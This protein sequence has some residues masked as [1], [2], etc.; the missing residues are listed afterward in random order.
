MIPLGDLSDALPPFLLSIETLSRNIKIGKRLILFNDF[1]RYLFK[2]QI[3]QCMVRSC[4]SSDARSLYTFS[5]QT[6]SLTPSSSTAAL[7]IPILSLSQWWINCSARRDVVS[8]L[9]KK[10]LSMVNSGVQRS[11]TT[12]WTFYAK[13]P[14]SLIRE[15]QANPKCQR[16]KEEIYIAIFL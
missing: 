12:F 11:A 16:I 7:L 6:E 1:S 13:T 15:Q 9:Y 5:S 2:T 14:E 3:L 8:Y 4:F 10:P